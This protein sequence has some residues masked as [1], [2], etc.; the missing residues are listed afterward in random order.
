M[1]IF[2]IR[3]TFLYPTSRE[4]EW[5]E[6]AEKIVTAIERRGWIIPGL[7]LEFDAYGSGEA[8]YQLLREI[9]GED[10]IMYFSRVQ[11]P[12][13][14]KAYNNTA[15]LSR[16]S[17]PQQI[18]EVY[19]DCSG[20][21]YYLYVGKDWEADKDS[22]FNNLKVHSKMDNKPRTYLRYKGVSLRCGRATYMEHDNDLGRE[23]SP[24]PNTCEPVSIPLHG[25]EGIYS[26]MIKWL[27]ENV[28]DK[29]NMEPGFTNHNV[30]QQPWQPEELIDYKGAWPLVFSYMKWQDNERIQTGKTN[31]A[32]LEPEYRH[33]S[34]SD[35][36]RL[37]PLGVQR[38]SSIDPFGYRFPEIAYEG[39]IWADPNQAITQESKWNA[40]ADH[41]NCWS[42]NNYIA[43]IKLKYA[44]HIYVA[45]HEAFEAKR[46]ELFDLLR[47][48]DPPRDRLTTRELGDTLAARGA[49]IIPINE[50][51]GDYKT[52]IVLINRELDFDEIEWTVDGKIDKN[53]VV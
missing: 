33:A 2:N 34:F 32:D 11:E 15:A 22:F 31:P 19:D 49:T 48:E 36:P 10:F 7:K 4:F 47:K 23:Y 20:P 16:V 39:F 25:P 27:T 50:Y 35:H 9:R 24:A 29:I 17:I 52:P 1:P 6:I 53:F 3:P 46:R 12:S 30:V 42:D 8:K 38:K 45:D 18:L 5:D 26:I 43:A 51:N 14:D 21:T 40:I 37:C 41:I 13:F 44:N 28:L